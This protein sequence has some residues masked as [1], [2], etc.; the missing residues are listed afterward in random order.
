MKIKGFLLVNKFVLLKTI[1]LLILCFAVLDNL[2]FLMIFVL[3]VK[4]NSR[5]IP[6]NNH[7]NEAKRVS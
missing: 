7:W 1:S 6:T 4:N 3:A 2:Y 5:A